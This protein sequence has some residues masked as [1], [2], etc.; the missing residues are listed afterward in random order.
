MRGK[1]SSDI[2]LVAAA[3]PT[4]PQSTHTKAAKPLSVYQSHA[5]SQFI[6]RNARCDYPTHL[7][8][9]TTEGGGPLL[10]GLGQGRLQQEGDRR[11][12]RLLPALHR[13]GQ[14]I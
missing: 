11:V 6:Q 13:Q 3:V 2:L 10:G 7:Q 5:R 4:S 9:G 14:A 8:R 1:R 12:H